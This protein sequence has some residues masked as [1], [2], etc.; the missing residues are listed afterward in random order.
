VTLDD[1][2]PGI[3]VDCYT[4]IHY[5][6][7]DDPTE[8]DEL[9]WDCERT[10]LE[11]DRDRLAAR[12]QE[13]EAELTR[14]RE[15]LRPA[16]AGE[17][18]KTIPGWRDMAPEEQAVY[19]DDLR[20]YLELVGDLERLRRLASD[21][22]AQME[23]CPECPWPYA[24]G[25]ELSFPI[26]ACSQ[27]ADKGAPALAPSLIA[28][29]PANKES[30]RCGAEGW[31]GGRRYRCEIAPGHTPPHVAPTQGGMISWEGAPA[32]ESDKEEFDAE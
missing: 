8:P 30:P 18:A 4:S 26:P 2:E 27:Q 29:P 7:G 16:S 3:C 12:V 17:V 19:V 5:S 13:L 23:Q 1:R 20:F 28:E 9:C 6:P 25:Q 15:L 21:A 31:H 10:R 11:A 14:L 24:L 32:A 22:C